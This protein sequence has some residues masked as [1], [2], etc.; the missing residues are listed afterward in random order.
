MKFEDAA[1]HMNDMR[2]VLS[3]NTDTVDIQRVSMIN[4]SKWARFH[5]CMKDA[6]SQK[7]PDIST[8]RQTKA[9]VLAYLEEQLKGI[10]VN[11]TMTQRLQQRSSGREHQET[12]LHQ[13]RIPALHRVGMR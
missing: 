6:L 7:P 5:T 13:Q 2:T 10:S 1:V 11:P 9:G 8:Y 12:S 3:E 4:F